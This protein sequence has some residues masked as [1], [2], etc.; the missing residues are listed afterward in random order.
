MVQLRV[1]Y[2]EQPHSRRLSSRHPRFV[3][4]MSRHSKAVSEGQPC[5]LDLV[6][7]LMV[8]TAAFL[9]ERGS[10]CDSGCRHCPFVID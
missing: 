4:I 1:K 7:G 8:F 10:C 3:E 2:L 9:A 6:T 5:Y